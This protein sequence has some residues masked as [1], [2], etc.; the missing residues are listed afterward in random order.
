MNFLPHAVLLSLERIH[1]L[2]NRICANVLQFITRKVQSFLFFSLPLI[3]TVIS[4]MLS[5][6][7]KKRREK[8]NSWRRDNGEIGLQTILEQIRRLMYLSTK[9]KKQNKRRQKKQS[10]A[11]LAKYDHVFVR[12]LHIFTSNFLSADLESRTSITVPLLANALEKKV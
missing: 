7:N 11:R 10:W 8:K 9:T 4:R 6:T 3:I 2:L 1:G 5:S 12:N